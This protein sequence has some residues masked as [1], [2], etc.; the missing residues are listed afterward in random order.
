M[1]KVPA[2]KNVK[3]PPVFRTL[4]D[5]GT[6]GPEFG[7]RPGT[8]VQRYVVNFALNAGGLG[9]YINY[10]VAILWAAKHCPWIEGKVFVSEYMVPLM[11]EI[12]KDHPDWEVFPGE[13]A[14]EFIDPQTPLIGPEIE[15]E[16][17]NVNPQLLNATGAISP[18]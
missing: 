7:F 17:R 2:H 12:F 10:S 16:G 4:V 1:A 9:D 11:K 6:Y 13:C 14:G 5:P 15:M 18:I 3:L 8:K